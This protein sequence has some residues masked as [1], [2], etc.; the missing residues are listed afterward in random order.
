MK[1]VKF[2]LVKNQNNNS[3]VYPD[4][5]GK[6][7]NSKILGEH[8]IADYYGS[9]PFDDYVTELPSLPTKITKRAFMQRFFQPERTLIRKSTDDIVIDIY[10]DLQSVRNV[11][12]AHPDVIAA[13]TYLTSVTILDAGRSDTII[14]NPITADEV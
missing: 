4:D 7:K 11:D 2:L 10:E 3:I 1:T 14:N 13:L 6:F 9:L 12:L 5:M 8:V